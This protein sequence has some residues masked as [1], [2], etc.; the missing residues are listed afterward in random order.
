MKRIVTI[1][2]ALTVSLSALA[3]EG[4][5]MLP[6]KGVSFSDLICIFAMSYH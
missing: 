4:M 1:I 2:T 6:P 3:D 5:W